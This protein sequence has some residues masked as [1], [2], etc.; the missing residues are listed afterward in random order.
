M[1]GKEFRPG[2]IAVIFLL[3]MAGACLNIVFGKV[4]PILFLDTIFT[5]TATLLAGP[6]WGA[7]TGASTN[8]IIHTIEFWGW[9]GYLFALCSIAT[10]LI[11]YLFMRL[12]PRELS[13]PHRQETS[14]DF[15]LLPKSRRFA[16]VMERLVVLILLS[17]ALCFAMSIM[18]GLISALIQIF[19]PARAGTPDLSPYYFYGMIPE[20]VSF[21][22]REIMIR[23]PMNIVDRL[24][25]AFSGYGFALALSFLYTICRKPAAKP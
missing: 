17:L 5:I 13:L 6:Y 24:I 25:S 2:R 10:A 4:S 21:I 18:G 16:L 12:F 8:I 3:C 20:N 9:E 19:N 14:Y 11:T 1:P 23:I 22:L 7:L 15:L